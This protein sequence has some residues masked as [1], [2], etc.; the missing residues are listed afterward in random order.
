MGR[1][2]FARVALI[3]AWIAFWLN[4]AFFP[5]CEAVAAAFGGHSASVSQPAL[6]AQPAHDSGET[7][8]DRPHHNPDTPCDFTLDAGQAI[9]TAYAALPTDRSQLEWFAIVTP[10]ASGL[11]AVTHFA[12]L[13]P[14]DYHHP[15]PLRRHLKTQRLLI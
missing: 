11:T 1:R 8:S 4:T 3:L 12:N 2:R 9:N 5:C 7:H 13:A 6:A 15:P 10:V 14:R